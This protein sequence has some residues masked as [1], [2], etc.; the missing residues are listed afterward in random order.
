MFSK[1]NMSKEKLAAKC[2]SGQRLWFGL[3]SLHLTCQKEYK[4]IK[5]IS[6]PRCWVQYAATGKRVRD[7]LEKESMG[8]PWTGRNNTQMKPGTLLKVVAKLPLNS[9]D[10]DF[11]L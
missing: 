3:L 9:P 7:Y 11:M 5:T 6:C 2:Q 4:V 1:E 8:Y 10:Q